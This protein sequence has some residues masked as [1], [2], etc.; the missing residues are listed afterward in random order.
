MQNNTRNIEK[1]ILSSAKKLTLSEFLSENLRVNSSQNRI[2]LNNNEQILQPKVMQLLLFLCA[3]NGQTL[4]KEQLNKMLWPDTQVGPDSLAN[5]M[6]RLRRALNDSSKQPQFIETVQRKG[7]RWLQ[8]VKLVKL[9]KR[10][11][12]VENTAT[13]KF[14]K[15]YVV[16]TALILISAVSYWLTKA[17]SKKFPFTDLTIKTTQSGMEVKIGIDSELNQD[18]QEKI[19]KEISRITGK[20]AEQMKITIDPDCTQEKINDNQTEDCNLTHEIE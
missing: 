2:Y 17:E 4:T 15:Y 10:V 16:V 6:T 8:S 5:T 13:R 3:A 19:K 9:V 18:N 11:Q 12:Q 1:D 20:S 14:L 7:Y